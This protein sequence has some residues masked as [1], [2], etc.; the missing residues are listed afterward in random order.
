MKNADPSS[1]GRRWAF[2]REMPHRTAGDNRD[3]PAIAEVSFSY[4]TDYGAGRAE[5]ARRALDLFLAMQDLGVGGS[6]CTNQDRARRL[7]RLK[8]PCPARRADSRATSSG[9]S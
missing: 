6:R 1:S 4:D 5:A 2:K 8:I 7:R 3:A 9:P